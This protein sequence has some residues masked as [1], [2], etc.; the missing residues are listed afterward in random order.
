MNPTPFDPAPWSRRRWWTIILLVFGVHVGLIFALGE[1]KGTVPR[2]VQV[3]RLR[4]VG[5]GGELLALGDPT[6]FAL[7]HPRGFAAPAWLPVPRVEF[8]PFKWTE[9]PRFLALPV[10]QLGATFLQFMQTNT[11]A[12]FEPETLP[13]PELIL[14]ELTPLFTPPTRSELRVRGDL[15]E[16]RL[17]NRPELPS[18][19]AADL[20]TNSVVRAQVDAAGNV[21]S[22]TLVAPGSGSKPADQRALE[23]ARSLRFAAVSQPPVISTNP[24][25]QLTSGALIFEWHTVPL[26]P[27]TNA[28]PTTPA[29]TPVIAP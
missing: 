4:L 12:R 17:L 9:N 26:P 16:R 22:F 20:L 21:H 6:L 29:V 23:L 14:P 2:P 11:F 7:P 13:A 27:A 18:W 3:A 1:R 8:A 10:A 25:G 24:L 19:P 5:E 28:P 15:A